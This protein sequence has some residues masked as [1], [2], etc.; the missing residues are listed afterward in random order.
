MMKASW[1]PIE[2]RSLD[3][4]YVVVALETPAATVVSYKGLYNW[5]LLS[6]YSLFFFVPH[7]DLLVFSTYNHAGVTTPD[8]FKAFQ[9]HYW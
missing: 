1:H 6:Y 2:W 8:T 7:H 9:Q 3:V 4:W 5:I